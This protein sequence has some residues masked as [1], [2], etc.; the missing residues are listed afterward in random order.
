M[1]ELVKITG[2]SKKEIEEC[3]RYDL[4]SISLF[5]PVNNED[6]DESELIDFLSDEKSDSQIYLYAE[7]NDLKEKKM[8]LL[9]T[10]FPTNTDNEKLNK[11]IIDIKK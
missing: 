1:D 3:M 2:Y 9:E 5:S 8:E 7:N 6:G 4:Q 10:A 11:K